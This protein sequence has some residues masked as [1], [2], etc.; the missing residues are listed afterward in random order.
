MQHFSQI[1]PRV[2]TLVLLISFVDYSYVIIINLSPLNVSLL[3]SVGTFVLKFNIGT[4]MILL[5]K[6]EITTFYIILIIL[7]DNAITLLLCIFILS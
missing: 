7:K 5:T 6:I 1:A 3:I 4:V 2:C